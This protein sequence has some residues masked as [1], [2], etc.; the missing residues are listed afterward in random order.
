MSSVWS[1]VHQFGRIDTSRYYYYMLP[2]CLF[3]LPFIHKN[4]SLYSP[5]TN[6]TQKHNSHL[7]STLLIGTWKNTKFHSSPFSIITHSVHTYTHSLKRNGRKKDGK[8]TFFYCFVFVGKAHDGNKMFTCNI[9][10]NVF[11]NDASLERHM[12]RHSTDKVSLGE[13]MTFFVSNKQ[14]RTIAALWMYGL[15]EDIC[16]QRTSR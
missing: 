1:G 13:F 15:S 8:K 2:Q 4:Y 9:C 14:I 7:L 11:A 6:A 5:N 16:S 12:K 10:M 3:I